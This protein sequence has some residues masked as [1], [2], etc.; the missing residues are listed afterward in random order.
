MWLPIMSKTRVKM[1]EISYN[2]SVENALGSSWWFNIYMVSLL[3]L[4]NDLEMI[5]CILSKVMWTLGYDRL[6]I[7][8]KKLVFLKASGWKYK[9][10]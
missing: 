8:G 9:S 4:R 10:N 6:Q 1:D 3:T 2:E 5:N 7:Q